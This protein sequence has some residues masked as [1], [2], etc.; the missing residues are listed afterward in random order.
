MQVNRTI[1][2]ALTKIYKQVRV[3]TK[4]LKPLQEANRVAVKKELEELK[5]LPVPKILER[6]LVV[7][8]MKPEVRHKR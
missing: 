1:S 7:K 8:L 5:S 2:S 4:K 6:V 3:E